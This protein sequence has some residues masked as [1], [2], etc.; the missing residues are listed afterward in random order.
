MVFVFILQ[1]LPFEKVE[2]FENISGKGV[3]GLINSEEILL[4]NESLLTPEILISLACRSETSLAFCPKM[5]RI[6]WS[7]PACNTGSYKLLQLG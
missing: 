4:G 6:S 7:V 2:S 5:L 1:N 3:K